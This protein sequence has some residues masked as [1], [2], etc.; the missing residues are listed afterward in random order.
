MKNA[1][2]LFLEHQLVSF[3][4]DGTL[5]VRSHAGKEVVTNSAKFVPLGHVGHGGAARVLSD[6]LG[7]VKM[8]AI[9]YA[10]RV[11]S[12]YWRCT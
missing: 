9:F 7:E 3:I 2:A 5:T 4:E 1:E 12:R 8:G 11:R 10:I 6:D